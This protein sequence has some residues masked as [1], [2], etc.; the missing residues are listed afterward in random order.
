MHIY[1]HIYA[2]M[3][4]FFSDSKPKGGEKTA[5]IE[6]TPAKEGTDKKKN[7]D[8]GEPKPSL[9]SNL[10]VPVSKEKIVDLGEAKSS[11]PGVK[12]KIPQ[13]AGIYTYTC[14]CICI[15]EFV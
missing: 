3:D 2:Q 11:M 12:S 13:E 4:F 5:F 6:L 7:T 8:L 1:I 10:K 15:Y 9:R 14:I